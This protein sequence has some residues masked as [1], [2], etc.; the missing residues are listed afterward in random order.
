MSGEAEGMAKCFESSRGPDTLEDEDQN[1]CSKAQC[2]VDP[3]PFSCEGK[4]EVEKDFFDQTK[5]EVRC[6][7][8]EEPLDCALDNFDLDN[9]LELIDGMPLH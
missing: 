9:T 5:L 8:D 6:S 4:V 2:S 1:D 3:I 7:Q